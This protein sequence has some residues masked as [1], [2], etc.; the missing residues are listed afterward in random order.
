MRYLRWLVMLALLVVIAWTIEQCFRAEC[1]DI[2][3]S[4]LGCHEPRP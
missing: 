3:R 4:D 2:A 1:N